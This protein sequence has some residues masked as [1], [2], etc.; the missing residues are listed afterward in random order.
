MTIWGNHSSTQF[1]D[2]SHATVELNGK[3]TSVTEA[4]NN[5][6]WLLGDF[7]KVNIYAVLHYGHFLSQTLHLH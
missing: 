7:V 1:P 5:D 2:S 6:P 3:D 4:L